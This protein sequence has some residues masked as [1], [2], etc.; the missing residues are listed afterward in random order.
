MTT[1]GFEIAL[2]ILENR[3][4]CLVGTSR[5]QWRI[6]KVAEAWMPLINR[7]R[8]EI[9]IDSTGI[10]SRVSNHEET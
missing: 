1:M 6:L 3:P 5:Q 2:A 10:A 4:F 8:R 7:Q 9:F